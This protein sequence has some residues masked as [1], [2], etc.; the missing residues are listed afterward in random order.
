MGVIKI[1]C[2]NNGEM[3]GAMDSSVN[4]TLGK[5]YEALGDNVSENDSVF[6]IINDIGNKASYYFGRFT[7]LEVSRHNK[8]EKLGI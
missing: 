3:D 4:L 7:T 2:I 6:N 5:V 1:V 8:L